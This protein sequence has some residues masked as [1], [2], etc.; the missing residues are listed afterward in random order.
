MEVFERCRKAIAYLS[1]VEA[2]EPLA[3][4]ETTKTEDQ[5][6]IKD[7]GNGLV[8]S[9]L[10]DMGEQFEY[11]NQG[12][13][14]EAAL[15]TDTLYHIGI[16]NLVDLANKHI[17]LKPHSNI[18]GI[19]VEGNFEASMMLLSTLWEKNLK[20]YVKGDFLLAIPARDVAAFGDS[21]NPEVATELQALIDRIWP[22]GE[23]LLSDKI[24]QRVDGEWQAYGVEERV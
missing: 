14:D 10:V 7:L 21:D 13:L 22:S 2:F 19:F 23:H 1:V 11:V 16:N 20:N 6:V 12:Q 4:D 15:T 9:Y 18:Y 17:R 3:T 5:P 8:V 24:Y